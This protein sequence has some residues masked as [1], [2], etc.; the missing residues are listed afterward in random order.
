MREE[1]LRELCKRRDRERQLKLRETD[2]CRDN[3]AVPQKGSVH[4]CTERRDPEKKTPESSSVT[5]TVPKPRATEWYS[6]PL[7]SVYPE[8]SR[9]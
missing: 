4:A 1:R 2:R 8:T 5:S 6:C 7:G 9:V 3:C